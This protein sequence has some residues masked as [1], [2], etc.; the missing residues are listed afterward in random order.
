MFNVEFYCF[1]MKASKNKYLSY[2]TRSSQSY[3]DN[4]YENIL[5]KLRTTN[6]LII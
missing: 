6:S 4:Y 2:S 5:Y 3:D 1:P